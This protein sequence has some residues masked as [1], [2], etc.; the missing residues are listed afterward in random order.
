M[1]EITMSSPDLTKVESAAVQQ[2]LGT[3]QLSMGP[4]IER[5]EETFASY[6]GARYAVAVNAG[7]SGLHLAVIAAG[8]REGDFVITTPFSFIASSNSILYE[9]GIPIFVDVEEKTGNIDPRIVRD[10]ARDIQTD[11]RRARRW[12]P[13]KSPHGPIPM[14]PRRLKAILP[15][16]IF[17]Q[18]ADMN[19]LLETA[20][21]HDLTVIEDACEAVGAMYRGRKVGLLGDAGV[22]AFYPNKQITTGEGGMI[23]TDNEDWHH[24]FRSLRNQGRDNFGP[25]MRHKRLGYNYRLNEMSAALGLI[26]TGRLEEILAKRATVARW[27]DERLSGLELIDVP[28]LSRTTSRMSWFVYAVRVK[29]PVDRDRLMRILNNIGVPCRPYFNALHLQPFYKE[30]FG[31]RSG[32]FPVSEYLSKVSLALPFSGLMT[33]EQV[34]YVCLQ[35][36]KQLS[37]ASA[38]QAS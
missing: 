36:K 37:R 28:H 31:Y 8:V 6:I 11:E 30:R 35:I 21:D 32:D 16:H 23:V 15:V 18:P 27:Y 24:L 17:G 5:F 38:A 3:R 7:T 4:Q 2:V 10:A 33:E 22:F 9:N 12:L 26:Q 34:D 13:R 19:P 14:R 25:W 29:P 1:K 20:A